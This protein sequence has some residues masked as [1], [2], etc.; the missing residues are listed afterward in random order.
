MAERTLEGRIDGL[1]FPDAPRWHGGRLWYSDPHAGHVARADGEGRVEVVTDV[2]GGP[3]GLGWLPD[4]RL[5]VVSTAERQLLRLDPGGLV[6]HADLGGTAKGDA[7][8][9]VV[10]RYGRAYVSN[11]GF[12]QQAGEDPQPTSLLLVELD[13][14]VHVV[15]EQLN[16]PNAMVITSDGTTLI[17][18]ESYSKRLLAFDIEPDGWLS[19]PRT[20]ADL[21][22]NVPDGICADEGGGVWVADPVYRQVFRVVEGGMITH[23]YETGDLAP[24]ACT[25]GGA[26]RTILYVCLAATSDPAITAQVR[27]GRIAAVP[28]DSPGDGFP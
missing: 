19:A 3:G 26:L 21:Q 7:N 24:Y 2:P 15:A 8:D 1:V 13:G 11:I 10:D 27:S 4:D 16:L 17:V 23:G 25:L 5:L 22:P 18:A 20:W 6:L 12:D 14:T 9:L 28:V